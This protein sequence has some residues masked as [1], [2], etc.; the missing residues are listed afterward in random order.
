MYQSTAYLVYAYHYWPE[1]LISDCH[2]ARASRPA[3][4]PSACDFSSSLLIAQADG[5][6]SSL[7]RRIHAFKIDILWRANERAAISSATAYITAAIRAL[8]TGN[9]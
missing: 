9:K 4:P 1:A 2:H 6:R 3:S 7:K 8:L 5:S